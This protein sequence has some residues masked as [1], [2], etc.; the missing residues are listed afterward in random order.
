[1]EM[2]QFN[3]SRRHFQQI[4]C[5][6]F[7]TRSLHGEN[8]LKQIVEICQEEYPNQVYILAHS[9]GIPLQ[10]EIL[11]IQFISKIPSTKQELRPGVLIITWH[12][13]PVH[14]G[15]EQQKLMLKQLIEIQNKSAMKLFMIFPRS[16][17]SRVRRGEFLMEILKISEN[18]HF[19]EYENEYKEE[20]KKI[21]RRSKMELTMLWNKINN[22]LIHNSPNIRSMLRS[23][24]IS[25][26][27]FYRLKK[28]APGLL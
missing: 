11:P 7:F 21:H 27:T 6:A 12:G 20:K 16:I 1:M 8:S 28:M 19:Y 5:G 2:R 17:W 4:T 14:G 24:K 23:L 3:L 22:Y 26:S 9:L 13:I 10:Q 25:A 18:Q 15:L